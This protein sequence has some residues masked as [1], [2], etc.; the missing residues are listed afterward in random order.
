[1]KITLFGGSFD[2]PHKGHIAVASQLGHQ[3]DKLIIV[4]NNSASCADRLLLCRLAFKDIPNAEVSDM[5]M[6]REGKSYT[7]DT[8]EELKSL[9]PHDD[10]SVAVGSDH[11]IDDWWR[12]DYIKENAGIISFLRDDD[13]ISSQSIREELRLR[14]ASDK[15]SD[16]VYAVIIK[17]GWY[18]ALPDLSWLREKA[19]EYLDSKRVAHVAGCEQEAVKLSKFY[20]EDEDAAATAAILHDITKKLTYDEQL[21]MIAKYGISCDEAELNAPKLLHAKTGA[22]LS[23]DLFGISDE[24]YS[25]IR[26]HTT[27]KPDM[28]LLEKIIYLADYIEPTRDFE[29]VDN[30]RNLAY[31]DLNACMTLGLEMSLEEVRGKG[32]EP[33]KDTKEAYEYYV[34]AKRDS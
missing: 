25:A 1:M 34:T 14:L 32:Q 16:D 4:P 33:Y 8:L 30:L 11:N 19:I 20:G 12:S 10:I 27:G 18:D 5:E 31:K 7:A 21:D 13:G 29:G 26:Y 3:C 15:L 6:L 9:Y 24:I 2:P 23:R 17:N 28:T 22:E